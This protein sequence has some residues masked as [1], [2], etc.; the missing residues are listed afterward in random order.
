MQATLRRPDA[1]SPLS[2]RG[3]SPALGGASP[4]LPDGRRFRV[5][6]SWSAKKQPPTLGRTYMPVV[7]GDL[8]IAV[9]EVDMA[10]NFVEVERSDGSKRGHVSLVMSGGGWRLKELEEGEEPAE[11]PPAISD[12]EEEEGGEDAGLQAEPTLEPEIVREPEIV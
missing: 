1:A 9:G 7:E 4:A 2:K 6:K 8:V 3:A 5:M 10:A 12:S 11:D